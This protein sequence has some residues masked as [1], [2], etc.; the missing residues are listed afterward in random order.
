LAEAEIEAVQASLGEFHNS[1]LKTA[2]A[3]LGARVARRKPKDE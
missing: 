1:R 3:R 2:L